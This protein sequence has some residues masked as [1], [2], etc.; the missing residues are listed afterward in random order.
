MLKK[1]SIWMASVANLK[2]REMLGDS[3][4]QVEF[5]LVGHEA[6]VSTKMR[7][8]AFRPIL[9]SMLRYE[10]R[11]IG[12]RMP[13]GNKEGD[14]ILPEIDGS[15]PEGFIPCTFVKSVHQGLG[16]AMTYRA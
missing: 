16:V 7:A 2:G 14:L 3:S 5:V 15:V 8:D 12:G 11:A 6:P 9:R 4:Y 10:D 13:C 1:S